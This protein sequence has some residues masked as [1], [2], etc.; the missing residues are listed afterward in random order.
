MPWAAL[1]ARSPADLNDGLI[2]GLVVGTAPGRAD[3]ACWAVTARE[4]VK[5]CTEVAAT[6]GRS[7]SG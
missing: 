4:E 7:D 1:P 2:V 6:P 3:L 5:A